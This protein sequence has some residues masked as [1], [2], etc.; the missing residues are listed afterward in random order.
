ML[1]LLLVKNYQP[2]PNWPILFLVVWGGMRW[3][4]FC[5]F[6]LKPSQGGSC[7]LPRWLIS[8][9]KFGYLRSLFP[10]FWLFFP[11]LECISSQRRKQVVFEEG[12]LKH[13][14]LSVS[15]WCWQT[16]PR[17]CGWCFGV[18]GV[19]YTSLSS[20]GRVSALESLFHRDGFEFHHVVCFP[21]VR[22]QTAVSVFTESLL[23]TLVGLLQNTLGLMFPISM[24]A[25]VFDWFDFINNFLST[26][27]AWISDLKPVGSYQMRLFPYADVNLCD[28]I[29]MISSPLS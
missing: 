7:W 16:L 12:V 15:C 18:L 19:F 5:G 26:C 29:L 4:V 21:L 3:I 10:D 28:W 8:G 23:L 24:A 11:T 25:N 22:V 20:A 13:V 9:V 14:C 17:S 6:A 1:P 27:W 2:T